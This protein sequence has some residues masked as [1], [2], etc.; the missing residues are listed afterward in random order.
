MNTTVSETEK[1]P[2][3][4]PQLHLKTPNVTEKPS[5]DTLASTNQAISTEKNGG[6]TTD[7]S[8]RSDVSSP[9]SNHQNPFDTDIEAM[10]TPSISRD[11]ATRM[12][13][14]MTTKCGG[15]DCQVWPTREHWIKKAKAAKTKRGCNCFAHL[16]RRNR[17]AINCAIVLIFLA[18]ALGVGIGISRALGAKY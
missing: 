13:T 11:P 5:S 15:P 9:R 1:A 14:N 6:V 3:Q 16:S 12:T 18:V 17:I 2:A 4:P 8:R 7:A 10:I